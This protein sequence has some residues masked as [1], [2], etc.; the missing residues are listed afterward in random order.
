MGKLYFGTRS[1]D[2]ER[3]LKGWNGETGV[4]VAIAAEDGVR[5]KRRGSGG[6]SANVERSTGLE[7]EGTVVVE[8]DVE[9]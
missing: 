2:E 6:V 9:A 8:D 5:E 4:C 1:A 7:L 3:G